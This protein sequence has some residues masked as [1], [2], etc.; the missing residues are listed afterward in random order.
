MK[1]TVLSIKEIIE[2]IGLFIKDIFNGI[3]DF[4]VHI[5]NFDLTSPE[6]ELVISYVL[7]F[8]LITY[9]YFLLLKFIVWSWDFLM[10]IIS[11]VDESSKEYKFLRDDE[12]VSKLQEIITRKWQLYLTILVIVGMITTGSLF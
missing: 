7:I 6:M 5:Y 9:L 10:D 11:K 1:F 4:F 2:R 3:T 8:G 12:K